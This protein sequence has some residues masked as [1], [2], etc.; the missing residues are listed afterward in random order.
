MFIGFQQ[1][2]YRIHLEKM[3]YADAELYCQ[4]YYNGHLLDLR[5]LPVDS[6]VNQLQGYIDTG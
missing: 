5:P 1:R 3:T 4:T 2:V 6:L